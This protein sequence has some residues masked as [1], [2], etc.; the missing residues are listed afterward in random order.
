MAVTKEELEKL[1]LPPL[2]HVICREDLPE[3][4]R[5]REEGYPDPHCL[6]PHS[7]VS[8]PEYK[9][10]STFTPGEKCFGKT[11]VVE[12]KEVISHSYTGHLVEIRAS[13]VLP[14]LITPNHPV[15]VARVK[16]K[17]DGS[18]GKGGGPRI[19]IGFTW[20]KAGELN[21][22]EDYL[23]IPILQGTVNVEELDL[24]PYVKGDYGY[25]GTKY[26]KIRLDPDMA[27][28]MG[29]YVAEGCVSGRDKERIRISLG[30]DEKDLL[31][32]VETVLRK[33]DIQYHID[34]TKTAIEIEISSRTIA[35]AFASWFGRNCY[36]K[37][38]PYFILLHRDRAILEA[39]L[40]GYIAGD[41]YI[42]KN[43]ERIKLTTVSKELALQLQLLAIRL[44]YR[45]L[46]YHIVPAH[47]RKRC[48]DYYN[49]ILHRKRAWSGQ[50]FTENY[51]LVRVTGI[52]QINYTGIVYNFE[53]S[54]GTYLVHNV[55]VHNCWDI[56]E[57]FL[58]AAKAGECSPLW[59]EARRLYWEAMHRAWGTYR[60]GRPFFDV[61]WCDVRKKVCWR[62]T[63]PNVKFRVIAEIIS[64]AMTFGIGRPGAGIFREIFGPPLKR[65][66]ER[67]KV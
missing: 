33:H 2:R 53:T 59:H 43:G 40:E 21:P 6:P 54:D 20:K 23:V 38:I 10:I 55:I 63:E 18:G 24:E 15:L 58:E 47:C 8:G 3:N 31:A 48:S 42:I 26:W 57:L 27:W 62:D 19:V 32:R 37:R 30:K 46:V 52:S 4:P 11:G 44:G 49:I 12:I 65:L 39:F 51:V 36:E 5:W 17:F 29:L 22:L 16:P 66:A 13:G 61:Y 7:L 25:F 60:R 67:L 14:L 1:E 9:P 56:D 34:E 45:A 35:R 41:G 64:A 28:L 50:I